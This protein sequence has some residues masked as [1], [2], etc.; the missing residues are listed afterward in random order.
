MRPDAEEPARR[1]ESAG[2]EAENGVETVALLAQWREGYDRLADL[3]ERQFSLVKDAVPAAKLVDATRSKQPDPKSADAV[4]A[5]IGDDF[6]REFGRLAEE[7]EAV[8][9][10]IERLQD[11]LRQRLGEEELIAAFER[12]IRT[13]AEKARVLT[14]ETARKVES[15]IILIGERLGSVRIHRKAMHAYYGMD[16]DDQVPLYIDEKK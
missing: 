14:F 11:E 9:R 5:G 6:W 15:M 8:Q 12:E 10:E 2:R 1:S 7:K 4:L 16:R 13:A 3:S